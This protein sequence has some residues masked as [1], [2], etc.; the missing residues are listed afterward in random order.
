MDPHNIPLALAA[1][2]G[3]GI[4][5]QWLAWRVKLPS[6]LLLLL[7]GFLVGPILGWFQPNDLLGDLMH[8]LISLAVGVI[9]F[10]GG[11]TLKLDELGK[12]GAIVLRMCTIGVLVTW[13]LAA[14]LLNGLVL[15]PWPLAILFGAVLTVTGPTVIGP[16]LRHVRPQGRVGPIA[17]WEGIVADVIGATLAVL[18]FHAISDSVHAES[19]TFWNTLG[20]LGMTVIVGTVAGLIGTAVLSVPLRRF[21]VPDS[22]HSPLTLAIVLMVFVLAD[23]LQH[24]SGLLAVTLMGFLM[25][26]QRGT[27]IHHIIE[28]KENLRTLLISSLFIVLAASLELESLQQLGWR[29]FTFVGLLILAIRPIAVRLA[30]AGSDA[31]RAERRFLAWLA[32]RGVVAAAITALFAGRLADPELMGDAVMPEAA[33]LVPLSFLVIIATVAVYGLSAA[34]IARRLKLATANPQGV[35]IIGGSPFAQAV[36]KALTDLKLPV[37]MMD[38]NRQSVAKARLEGIRAF[39]GSA[40]A[41]DAEEHVPLGGIGRVLALTSNDEVNSLALVHLM[42]LFGRA[43]IYQ[44]VPSGFSA[45]KETADNLRGRYLFHPKAS[46]AELESRLR[47]GGRIAVTP[48]SEEFTFDDFMAHHEQSALPLFRLTAEG[49]LGIFVN[50][51]TVAPNP[52]DRL[53]SLVEPEEPETKKATKKPADDSAAPSLGVQA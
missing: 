52:G 33:R 25:A 15:L 42:E 36:A 45:K 47:A 18:T 5:A 43:E 17:N 40:L 38:T 32:P 2:I 16:L 39:Y 19:S 24:E 37:I 13:V 48:L 41:A 31:N 3:L 9:L 35:W 11:L 22:L 6:I 4:G 50:D 20:G 10:E 23:R 7:T 27:S 44:L 49:N 21:W 12:I 46:F 34:P 14:G 51:A 29:E 1:I 8:P 26:N 30:L 53:I 28:F